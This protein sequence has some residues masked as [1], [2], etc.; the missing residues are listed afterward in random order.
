[1]KGLRHVIITI[2]VLVLIICTGVF[3][4]SA[5]E[6]PIELEPIYET[7]PL[8]SDRTIG[9]IAPILG[10]E[11]EKAVA[12]PATSLD[13]AAVFLRNAMEA[14]TESVR[15]AM[16]DGHNPVSEDAYYIWNLAFAETG[17]PTHGDYLDWHW[18]SWGCAWDY[19]WEGNIYRYYM[20]FSV[21]YYTTAQQEA[22]LTVRVNEIMESF[23]FTSSTS[24]YDKV[25]TIYSWVTENIAYDYTSSGSMKQTAYNGVIKGTC[26]CQ[27]YAS[28]M[29][30]MLLQ[31]GVSA[32]IVP[33]DTNATPTPSGDDLEDN[34]GWNIVKLGTKWYN[35]DATWDA[36]FGEENW[37][38]FLVCL[39]NF[40]DH[41]RWPDY[42]TA[43]FHIDYPMAEE[44]YSPYIATG[45]CGDELVWTLDNDGTLTISGTGAMYDYASHSDV[46]WKDN[47][48]AI[49]KLIF[50]DS[51]TTIGDY[52]FIYCD[53]L[54]DV[55][56]PDK[57]TTIGK[58]AFYKCRGLKN[59]TIGNG[60]EVIGVSSFECCVGL[61]NIT[62]GNGV[63]VIDDYA[64]SECESLTSIT[65]PDSVIT[66]DF[67]A[68][69]RC[70]GLTD[71]TV[72]NGVTTIGQEAFCYCGGIT[73]VILP[74]SVTTI[75][76][77]AFYS[78]RN[79]LSLTIGSGVT[80]V[81]GSAFGGCI[82]LKEIN[83]KDR[84]SVV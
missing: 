71:I 74:D 75:G 56:I 7:N 4:V 12:Y 10:A 33:G 37:A 65:I 28:I 73:D 30:R 62:I 84:K 32:R 16:P 76:S 80:S 46:P 51:V 49:K 79:L 69:Y 57:V 42:D 36:G 15:I 17:I 23:A 50:E 27:G 6:T 66:I 83:F 48:S 34:H 14:R 68:F 8:F 70:F 67:R 63:K 59:V 13:D 77:H 24:D 39:E 29:Y 47:R 9:E 11:K 81:A 31:A 38:Y 61:E 22:E 52:A 54:V 64:F 18:T 21:T 60:V 58:F 43:Q 45:I 19:E 26:V 2:A 5:T 53:G 78:C 41:Y 3:A 55:A 40:G 20:T 44:D 72:G 35:L 82:N 1:M 25:K